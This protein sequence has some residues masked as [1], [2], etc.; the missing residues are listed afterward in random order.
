MIPALSQTPNDWSVFCEGWL[1]LDREKEGFDRP[2]EIWSGEIPLP[3][4]KV[5]EVQTF[6]SRVLDCPFKIWTLL[7]NQIRKPEVWICQAISYNY[8]C[9]IVTESNMRLLKPRPPPEASPAHNQALSWQP[10][11]LRQPSGQVPWKFLKGLVSRSIAQLFSRPLP[12]V[13]FH[14]GLPL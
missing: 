1:E 10:S 13:A 6:S 4:K 9:R 2:T 5:A 3:W 7:F 12:A 8:I 11:F 14:L